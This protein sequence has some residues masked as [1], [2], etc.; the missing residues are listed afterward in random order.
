MVVQGPHRRSVIDLEVHGVVGV[1]LIDATGGDAAK[2]ERH[3]GAEQTSLDRDPDIVIRFTESLSVPA[4]TY[5]GL[6]SAAFADDGFYILD[7][8]EGKIQ[9]R[10]HFDQIGGRCELL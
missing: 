5:V 10:I 6:H 1:R 8:N 9:A 3:L 4:I 2:V 7:K